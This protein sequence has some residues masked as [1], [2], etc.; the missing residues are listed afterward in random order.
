MFED[1]GL[2]LGGR[3]Q[4]VGLKIAA[5]GG[6]RLKQEIQQSR[7]LLAGDLPETGVEFAGIWAVVGRQADAG[8]QHSGAAGSCRSDHGIEV[9]AHLVERQPAQTVVGAEGDNDNG[10]LVFEE[11]RFETG[12]P[13]S[14]GFAGNREVGNA[15]IKAF[16]GDLPGQQ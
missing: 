10:R 14:C 1:Q 6:D 9:V 5:F 7:F 2:C 16:S 4:I 15:I 12:A 11:R 8:E 13:A 3:V